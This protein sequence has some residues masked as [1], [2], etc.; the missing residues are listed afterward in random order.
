MFHLP[1]RLY[2]VLIAGIGLGLGLWAAGAAGTDLGVTSVLAQEQA[3]FSTGVQLVEV[4]AT[5]TDQRGGLVTGLR[6]SDFEVY[7]NDEKQTI[8]TFTAGEFPA[9]VVLGVDRSLSMAGEPLRLAKLAS[10]GFLRQLKPDDR[11]MVVAIS[12]QADVIAQLSTDRAAQSDAIA[13]LDPWSTTALHDS[14]IGTLDRLDGEPG[15]QALV[16]FSDGADRYSHSTAAEVVDRA[17]RSHAL[18][19]LITIGKK[20]LPLAAELAAVTGGR[21]FLIKN[22]KQLDATLTTIAQEIRY[23]YLLGYTPTTALPKGNREWR[24]LRVVVRSQPT[25]VRVRARDGYTTE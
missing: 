24:S 9:T 5:V 1:H 18:V 3:Q 16:V 23:Q 10:Q 4:Y 12:N 22:A 8:S 6:A 17:R 7:E 11:S 14:I 15:R 21:S 25:G 20:R 13:A 2:H 19:Y